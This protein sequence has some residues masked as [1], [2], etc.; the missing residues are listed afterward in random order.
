MGRA[1]AILL[2]TLF[3]AVLIF[4]GF[5]SLR[6][7]GLLPWGINACPEPA[8][9]RRSDLAA[10]RREDLLR[11]R[12]ELLAGTNLAPQCRIPAAAP[13]PEPE[14]EPE[15]QEALNCQP[16][17]TDEVVVLLDVSPSMKYDFATDP[18]VTARLDEIE[19]I[20][21]SAGGFLSNDLAREYDRLS[22]RLANGPGEDRIDVAKGALAEL[23]RIAPPGTAINLLTFAECRR[24]PRREG[25]FAAGDPAYEERVRRL[26][27]RSSTALAEA[28]DALPGLTEA[29]RVPDRP[30][31]IV[32]FT[33][34]EDNCGGDPCAA[35]R[36]MKAAL[37]YAQV[38]VISMAREANDNACVAEGAEGE[39]FYATQ[40]A[41][42]AKRLRQATGQLTA[43]ECA[44][45]APG[46]GA[47][48]DST[49]GDRVK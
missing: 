39:F 8:P 31:N 22:N 38:S 16:P 45:L 1:A 5:V 3:A 27:L 36:R 32:I 2:W 6:A 34:G 9:S 48:T 24:P 11:Q 47:G 10:D 35:A 44:A 18:A 20:A 29:G 7:C 23:G 41:E 49:E 13:E 17:Q 28:I 12:A 4:G 46:G 26:A 33:D 15:P 43:E 21:A 19:A 37:P 40:V 14:P 30:V 42:L 25:V